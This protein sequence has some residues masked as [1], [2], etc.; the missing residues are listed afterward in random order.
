MTNATRILLVEDEDFVRSSLVAL[1]EEE[2]Y[3]VEAVESVD[4]AE[5]VLA[6]E[7]PDLVLTDLRLPGRDG[8]ALLERV[9]ASTPV[10]LISGHGTLEEAVDAMRRGA[11]DFVQKPVDPERLVAT[12]A[13]ARE[14]AVLV[15]QVQRLRRSLS[16]MEDRSTLVGSS[17]GLEELRAQVR[18]VAP[19]ETPVLVQGESG[20]GK[21]LVARELHRQSGRADGP[22]VL[23]NCGALPVEGF[24]AE[25]FGRARSAG[26]ESLGRLEESAGGTLVLDDVEALAAES[27][28]TLLQVLEDGTYRRLGDTR[29][30]RLDARVVAITN[31]D[32]GERVQAGT[33]RADLFYRLNVFPLELPPL[34]AH[35]ED[36]GE[37]ASSLFESIRAR[38]GGASAPRALDT[39][40]LAVL[41][42]YDWPGNVREL[43]NVLERAA[44][45]AASPGE[46]DA[47][48]L[49]RLLA[50]APRVDA[51]PTTLVIKE[52]LEALERELVLAA[53]AQ[54]DGNRKQASELLGI[55]P[56]NFSYY[57]R[58]H[59][60]GG[61]V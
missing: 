18:R 42:G 26:T 59:A 17:S 7:A 14:H 12:L 45:L 35:L 13:R 29:P 2:G 9:D 19:T 30:R 22:F 46:V 6:R 5:G 11:Y 41:S 27:Q 32:L 54:T 28:A 1:L 34:R 33:F 60:L 49:R 52:R 44:I 10:V 21:E 15:G 3:E 38:V 40:A 50:G 43:R 20:T 58:K 39:T 16:R 48:L 24:E 23:L 55:D 53:L 31:E 36:L 61:E 8:D 4:A 37:I 47:Q 57:V 56:K 51:A 25:L